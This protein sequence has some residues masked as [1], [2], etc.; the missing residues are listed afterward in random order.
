MFLIKVKFTTPARRKYYKQTKAPHKTFIKIYFPILACLKHIKNHPFT[1]S[2]THARFTGT[3]VSP[4]DSYIFD[5][6]VACAYSLSNSSTYSSRGRRGP[7]YVSC[8]YMLIVGCIYIEIQPP[9]LC[10]PS[11]RCPTKQHLSKGRICSS[12]FFILGLHASI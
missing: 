8:C 11:N 4:G 3:A 12:I 1:S 10:K 2:R 7:I 6:R 9:S 5:T